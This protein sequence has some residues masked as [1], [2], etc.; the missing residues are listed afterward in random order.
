M[1]IGA[2]K[3]SRHEE[4]S[5]LQTEESIKGCTFKPTI[6]KKK[7]TNKKEGDEKGDGFERLY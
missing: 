2:Q 4:K 5:K 1:D 3:K 6:L 7:N